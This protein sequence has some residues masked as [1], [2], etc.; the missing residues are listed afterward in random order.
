MSF[1]GIHVTMKRKELICSFLTCAVWHVEFTAS[2]FILKILRS[3]FHFAVQLVIHRIAL[4]PLIFHANAIRFC[5]I[6]DLENRK[7]IPKQWKWALM[8]SIMEE[9][10]DWRA[11]GIYLRTKWVIPKILSTTKFLIFW[12]TCM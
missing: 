6:S 4:Q 3:A 5:Q 11:H 9:L 7:V 2:T 8:A 10:N 1:S 12:Y